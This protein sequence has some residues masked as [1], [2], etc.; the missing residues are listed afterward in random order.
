MLTLGLKEI[1]I[2]TT[3]QYRKLFI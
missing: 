3:P 1:I 2:V